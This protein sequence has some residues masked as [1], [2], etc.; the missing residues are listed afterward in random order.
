MN[1]IHLKF[2]KN[3]LIIT[4]RNTN[5]PNSTTTETSTYA[6]T[7]VQWLLVVICLLYKWF[8]VYYY[9]ICKKTQE[10]LFRANYEY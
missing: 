1:D 3:F 8:K 5:D 10:L 6:P 7:V 4:L 2:L 9:Y